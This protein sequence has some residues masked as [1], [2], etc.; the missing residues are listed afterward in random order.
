MSITMLSDFRVQHPDWLGEQVVN[1]IA[2]MRAEGLASLD[3]LG[4]D[5]MRVRANAGSGSFKS[6]EKLEQLREEAEQQWERPQDEFEQEEQLSPR[7]RA[8][9]K[10]AARERL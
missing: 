2:A 6:A 7:Q 9:R 4:Q 1:N 5:G 3:K 10:R 8:A